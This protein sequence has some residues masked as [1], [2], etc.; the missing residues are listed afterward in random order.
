MALK[1]PRARAHDDIEF[2]ARVVTALLLAKGKGHQAVLLSRNPCRDMR[3]NLAV[4]LSCPWA[5]VLAGICGAVSGASSTSS[6]CA[7]RPGSRLCVPAR[8]VS[9]GVLARALDNIPILSYLLLRGRYLFFL[10]ISDFYFHVLERE[11]VGDGDGKL[12]AAIGAVL[13]WRVLPFVVFVAASVGALTNIPL[14][15]ARHPRRRGRDGCAEAAD[16]DS[17][18]SF[19]L[20]GRAR[21]PARLAPTAG[22]VDRRIAT[23]P[24]DGSF[25]LNKPSLTTVWPAS[26]SPP[27]GTV[28]RTAHRR[29]S[30]DGVKTL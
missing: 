23:R 6:S 20:S 24:V 12:L 29:H 19:S 17:F 28:G 4:L 13:D 26:G 1:V 27:R 5:T 14:T 2:G 25:V 22:A 7:C 10:A 8:C 3:E 15:S 9:C 21:L 11:G 18:R 16:A 30:G